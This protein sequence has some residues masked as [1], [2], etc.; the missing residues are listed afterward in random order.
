MRIKVH[1]GETSFFHETLADTQEILEITEHESCSFRQ[2]LKICADRDFHLLDSKYERMSELFVSSSFVAPLLI[3]RHALKSRLDEAASEIDRVLEEPGNSKYL[4]TWTKIKSFLDSLKRSKVDRGSLKALI[5]SKGEHGHRAFESFSPDAKGFAKRVK[6]STCG[7]VTGRLTVES[8]PQILTTHHDVRK[9][10]RSSFDRGGIYQID[11]TSMEPR[12]ALIESGLPTPD[13]VYL[14]LSEKFPSMSR[15]VLKSAMLTTLYGGSLQKISEMVGDIS[16]SA[17]LLEEVSSKFGLEALE[18]RLEKEAQS[19]L[20]RNAFGR[21]LREA[22][23]NPRLR[24]NHFLQSSAAE[25]SIL[26]FREFCENLGDSVRP[27]FVIHDA[28][29]VDADETHS[30]ETLEKCF[31]KVQLRGS[32]MPV[33][34]D[35]LTHN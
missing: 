20:V 7:T 35:A 23:L 6:Y 3:P 29:I 5:E 1:F 9:C 15:K 12:I 4:E 30:S 8:G 26:L 34:I 14:D 21:P 10:L 19:G 25:A 22:T 31:Q 16:L 13:D 2:F 33:K 27:L 17:K 24:I 11:F 28:L 32:S 18:R